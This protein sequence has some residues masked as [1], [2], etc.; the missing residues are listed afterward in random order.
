MTSRKRRWEARAGRASPS[1]PPP[2][3]VSSRLHESARMRETASR[4]RGSASDPQAYSRWTVAWREHE[5]TNQMRG[6]RASGSVRA[7]GA[8]ISSGNPAC[9]HPKTFSRIA[10]KF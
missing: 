8:A 4:V 7:R 5:T 1:I 6:L 3:R 10:I 2:S 9:W